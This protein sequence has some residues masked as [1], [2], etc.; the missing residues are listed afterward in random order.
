MD[1]VTPV[2]ARVKNEGQRT[3]KWVQ[4]SQVSGE[5]FRGCHE[6]YEWMV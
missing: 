2:S 3:T 5:R 6:F 4:R 1:A